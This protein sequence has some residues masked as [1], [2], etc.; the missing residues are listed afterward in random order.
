MNG[1]PFFDTHV[2]LYAFSADPSR[3]G[4]AQGLFQSGGS[5]SVQVRNEF[6]AVA[7]RKL[8]ETSPEIRWALAIRRAFFPTPLDLTL[9]THDRAIN[10]AGRYGLSINDSLI[11]AAAIQSGGS[12]L[13][14]E[15]MRDGQTIE[16]VTIRNPF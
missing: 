13:Y 4:V 15:D 9:E 16:G 5:I 6:V 12:I 10:I 1:K 2:I 7:R 3:S 8:H 14:S 11:V